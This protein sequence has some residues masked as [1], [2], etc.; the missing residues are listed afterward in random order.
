MV[1]VL[2]ALGVDSVSEGNPQPDNLNFRDKLALQESKQRYELEMQANRLEH[3]RNMAASERNAKSWRDGLGSVVSMVAGAYVAVKTK[4]VSKGVAAGLGVKT[5]I[6]IDSTPNAD[7][8]LRSTYHNAGNSYY[9][10]GSSRFIYEPTLPSEGSPEKAAPILPFQPSVEP[11]NTLSDHDLESAFAKSKLREKFI[12]GGKSDGRGLTTSNFNDSTCSDMNS[13]AASGLFFLDNLSFSSFFQLIFKNLSVR[14]SS[15]VPQS[16]KSLDVN[17]PSSLGPLNSDGVLEL[18][19]QYNNYVTFLVIMTFLCI[20]I[21]SSLAT[22][23]I[24][25][26]YKDTFVKFLSE[27]NLKLL[28]RLAERLSVLNK[29]LIFYHLIFLLIC[30]FSMFYFNISFFHKPFPTLP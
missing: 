12:A 7:L 2:P 6:S 27:R 5:G 19:W 17:L 21:L 28:L 1:G 11:C 3:E 20:L 8:S 26:M 23:L 22:N 4:A 15:V 14:I 13:E 9:T 30:L 25:F 18:F 24:F 16:I 29:A 10:F